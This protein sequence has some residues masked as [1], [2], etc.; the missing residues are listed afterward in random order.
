[1]PPHGYLKDTEIAQIL[2][3]VRSSFGNNSSAITAN[4]V[5]RYRAVRR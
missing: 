5:S 3:Y 4:E 2:T 1:M